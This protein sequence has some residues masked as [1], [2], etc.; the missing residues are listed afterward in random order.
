MRNLCG[1]ANT[2]AQRGVQVNGLA[3]VHRVRPHLD[4]QRAAVERLH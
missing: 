2:L 1:H 3:D 4:G